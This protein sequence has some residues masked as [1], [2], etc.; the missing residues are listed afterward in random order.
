MIFTARAAHILAAIALFVNVAQGA[1]IS[2][3]HPYP[4]A[5]AGDC[6]KLIGDNLSNDTE[7]SCT[8]GPVKITN[9]MCAIVTRCTQGPANVTIDDVV[10][11]SL[12]VIGACALSDY[13]SI[14]GAYT[15]DDGVKTCYLYPGR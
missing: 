14:S 13:G 1:T 3:C 9:G 7:V 5:A 10:R 2:N 6:L 4:G 8:N 15:T 12:T 11:R